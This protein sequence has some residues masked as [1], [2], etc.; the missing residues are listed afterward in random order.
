MCE[1]TH[2]QEV[3]A[4]TSARGALNVTPTSPPD[5]PHTG[6]SPHE[7]YMRPGGVWPLHVSAYTTELDGDTEAAAKLNTEIDRRQA[8][9]LA[10]FGVALRTEVAK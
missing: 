5:T 4:R 8:A 6:L 1:L 3:F 2:R 10:S 7:Q 9:F